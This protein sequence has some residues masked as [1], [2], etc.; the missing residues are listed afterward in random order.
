MR[1]FAWGE[2][3]RSGKVSILK[4]S[5]KCNVVSNRL[6]SER[7]S[8]MVAL[9][10]EY[11]TGVPDLYTNQPRQFHVSVPCHKKAVCAGPA[12]IVFRVRRE[13]EREREQWKS[14]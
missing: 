3:L 2:V 1:C 13:R 4:S 12:T 5:H 7:V 10:T 11:A 14:E 9:D 8:T 6:F